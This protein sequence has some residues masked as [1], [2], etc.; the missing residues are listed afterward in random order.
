M[1]RKTILYLKRIIIVLYWFIISIT[2]IACSYV[3]YH[4]E[5][6]VA[7]FKITNPFYEYVEKMPFWLYLVIC[8][9]VFSLFIFLFFVTLSVYFNIYRN[10]ASKTTERYI[11]FFAFVLTTYCLSNVYKET[12][13]QNNLFERLKPFVKKRIQL[14]ALFWVYTKLQETLTIDLSIKFKSLLKNLN[15]YRKIESFLY[16]DDFADRILAMKVLSYLRIN[17]YDKQIVKY[18]VSNNFALR[19]EAN[20][21]LIRLMKKDEHLVRFI[22]EKH[23]LSV[24]DINIIVNAVLKNYKLDI[25]YKALLSSK[26]PKKIML[27][28]MLAKNRFSKDKSNLTLILNHIGNTDALLNKLAWEALITIVPED[29]VMDTIIARFQ[30]EPEDVKLFILKNIHS[31]ENH[32]FFSF[33]KEIVNDETLL[34]KIEALNTLFE[35]DFDAL[36]NYANSQ[37]P[38]IQKAYEEVVCFYINR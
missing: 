35:N 18:S 21:A 12:R 11:K 19:T 36:G 6:Q 7:Q 33:L 23:Q 38:E 27:G 4:H 26:N 15:L 28:L 10:R 29:E 24:L 13:F 17:D 20:A 34:L 8:F 37:N 3:F 16:G 32:R 1:G 22:R 14:E 2:V 9:T 25:D 30:E 5:T 31:S